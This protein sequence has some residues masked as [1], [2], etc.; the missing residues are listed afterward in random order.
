MGHAGEDRALEA[1]VLL[2]W[3]EALSRCPSAADVIGM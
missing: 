3:G 1:G 2:F